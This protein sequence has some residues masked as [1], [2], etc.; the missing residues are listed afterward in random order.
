MLHRFVDDEGRVDY[1]ALKQDPGDLDRYF[2]QIAA[3]SPD[4]HPELFPTEHSKLAYWINAYNAAVMETVL[5]Y[6]PIASV[7]DVDTPFPIGLF[8]NKAGFFLFQRVRFGDDTT[9]LYALEHDVV[10]DRFEDPRVHFALNCA[11]GGC[12][13]LPMR[14]FTAEHLDEQLD[15]ETRKFLA[16]DRNLA[17]DHSAKAVYLSSI[18]DWYEDDFLEWKAAQLPRENPTLLDYAA[19]YVPAD[20]G[21][22]LKRAQAYEIRFV[23]YDWGLNDQNRS[24]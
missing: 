20:R 24:G 3:Y 8:T 22:E 16:E 2:A 11:S 23:P 19:L 17:I 7:T 21:E 12:P 6:Y 18:F 9:S 1:A 4:S 13:R 14:A 5:T 10:R 15:A